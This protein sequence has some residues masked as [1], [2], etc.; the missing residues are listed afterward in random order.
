MIGQLPLGLFGKTVVF[1][2]HSDQPG[3]GRRV[4]CSLRFGAR[5]SCA[6]QPMAWAGEIARHRSHLISTH[7]G[8][9]AIRFQMRH[10]ENRRMRLLGEK[11]G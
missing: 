1:L 2:S 8:K 7:Q 6:L 5:L 3:S 10:E 4:S 11:I 9:S